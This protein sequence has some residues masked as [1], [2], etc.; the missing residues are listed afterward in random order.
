MGMVQADDETREPVAGQKPEPA[1]PPKANRIMP[2][3][4]DRDL[5]MKRNEVKRLFRR[6]KR[7][8]SVFTRIDKFEAVFN[9]FMNFVLIADVIKPPIP[10]MLPRSRVSSLELVPARKIPKSR[11][12]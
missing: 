7:F 5:S 4:Y 6:I 8:R 1:A 3:E 11:I 9:C 2:W 12:P 10:I